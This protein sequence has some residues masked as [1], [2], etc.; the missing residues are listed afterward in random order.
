MIGSPA[1]IS[2]CKT[3]RGKLSSEGGIWCLLDAEVPMLRLWTG[4]AS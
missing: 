2:F 3:G 4:A 1:E